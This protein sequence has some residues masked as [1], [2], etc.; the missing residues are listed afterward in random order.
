MQ[1][2]FNPFNEFVFFWRVDVMEAMLLLS[3]NISILSAD[4]HIKE[5]QQNALHC[6]K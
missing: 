5:V 2:W 3:P 4:M 1:F 6:E